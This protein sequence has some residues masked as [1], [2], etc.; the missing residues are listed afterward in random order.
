M[1]PAKTELD[2]SADL[3]EA[4]RSDYVSLP[5]RLA[6]S[7][8][9]QNDLTNHGR[10]FYTDPREAFTPQMVGTLKREYPL[11]FISTLEVPADCWSLLLEEA[12]KSQH[13]QLERGILFTGDV[14]D[15]G[16]AVVT[17]AIPHDE[18]VEAFGVRSFQFNFHPHGI[19]ACTCDY[20]ARVGSRDVPLL[21]AHTHPGRF[22]LPT[23]QD[24][25]SY[26]FVGLLHAV[27]SS[28]QSGF[29]CWRKN[30]DTFSV[31][32]PDSGE[33]GVSHSSQPMTAWMEAFSSYRRIVKY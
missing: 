15:E 6:S 28:D 18:L 11:E 2:G 26:T 20:P 8:F 27:M 14:P 32:V 24:L 31:R 22:C 19:Y 7:Y 9:E 33:P 4:G 25:L 23:P 10:P 1:L 5:R 12:G 17:G 30:D 13:L 21:Y 16:R 29:S 3:P